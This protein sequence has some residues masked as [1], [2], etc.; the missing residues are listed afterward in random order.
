MVALKRSLLNR[1]Y[2]LINVLKTLSSII[3]M[4]SFYVILLPKITSRYFTWLTKGIFRPLN[5][6]QGPKAMRKVD[7]LSLI[8][9]DF[10]VPALIPRLNSTETSLHLSENI[11]LF[12]VCLI[13]TCVIRDL[14]RHRVSVRVTLRLAVYRQSVRLGD[15]PLE[16]TSHFF[17]P[18]RTLVVI[19]LM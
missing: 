14:D 13:Y 5:E 6:P 9:I 1:E 19:V 3:S 7:G 17:F 18:N 16:M 12:A 10:Y 4:C 8:F 2:I 15:K 11:T